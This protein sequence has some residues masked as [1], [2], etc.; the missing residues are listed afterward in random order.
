[1]TTPEAAL[2]AATRTSVAVTASNDSSTDL[3]SFLNG[4]DAASKFYNGRRV[5]AD[6]FRVRTGRPSQFD[7]SVNQP[8]LNRDQRVESPSDRGINAAADS[9]DVTGD[10][11]QVNRRVLQRL[12][13]STS[14]V[15]AAVSVL[16]GHDFPHSSVGETPKAN[17]SGLGASDVSGSEPADGDPA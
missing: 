9:S 8:S 4:F 6:R 11:I 1:M 3:I 2:L 10:F 15:V 17:G 12:I 7:Q 14:N 16:V 13:D 5:E